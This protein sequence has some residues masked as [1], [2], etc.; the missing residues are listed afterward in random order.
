MKTLLV[1]FVAVVVVAGGAIGLVDGKDDKK[2]DLDKA[3]DTVDRIRQPDP[4]SVSTG[5]K[6][7]PVGVPAEEFK[8]KGPSVRPKEP[9][10]PS[11]DDSKSKKKP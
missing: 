1:L 11:T 8:P 5:T 3:K 4:P 2:L 6:P 9:P 10:S 7:S